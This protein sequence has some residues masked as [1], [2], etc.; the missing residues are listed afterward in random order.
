MKRSTS[1]PLPKAKRKRLT[2]EE[3]RKVIADINSGQH[4]RT[5]MATYG[6]GEQTVRDIKKKE[7]ELDRFQIQ[8]TV[9]NRKSLRRPVI[10]LKLI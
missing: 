10:L 8:F 2:I 4:I 6:I 1:N 3:K 9:K 5:V 7:T